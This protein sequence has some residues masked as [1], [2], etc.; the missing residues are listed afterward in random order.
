MLETLRKHHYV[1][2]SVIAAV[3]I[4]SFTFLY[5]PNQRMGSGTRIGNIYGRDFTAG[6]K[7][8]IDEMG[9]V[10]G[11]LGGMI[12]GN[13]YMAR[14]SDPSQKFINTLSSISN[15]SSSV[16][17]SVP[18]AFPAAI[19][20]HASVVNWQVNP[21]VEATPIS[22]PAI[23]GATTWLSRA[24]DEVSTFTTAR[25]FWPRSLA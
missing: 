20:R 10:A 2:M 5:N 11:R 9:A 17:L 16:A 7:K 19:A 8:A 25:I 6:E 22:G 23:I 13:D 1:L 3:V 15:R 21:L 24:I 12:E 18:R 14:F 4:V